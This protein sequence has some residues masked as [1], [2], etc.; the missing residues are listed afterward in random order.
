MLIPESVITWDNHTGQW[1]VWYSTVSVLANQH[2]TVIYVPLN[3]RRESHE[4]SWP[5][6]IKQIGR[7]NEH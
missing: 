1:Y 3:Y 6:Y 7:N 2:K 4:N 5:V